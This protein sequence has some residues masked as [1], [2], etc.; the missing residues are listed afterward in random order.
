[1]S[2]YAS[3]VGSM[4]YVMVCTCSD[5]SHVVSVDSKFM[6][7]PGKIHWE[8][9][10][11]IFQYLK[12]IVDMGLV[13]GKYNTTNNIIGYVD[14]DYACD[15]DKRRSLTVYVFTLLGCAISWKATLQ[16][17]VT[18]STTETEY[19]AAVEAVKEAI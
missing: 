9:V 14:S 18:L 15:L 3:V 11:C 19:M 4:I 17:T 16:S 2:P 8:A 12:G 6:A 1:M 5:I 7:S 13:F 10:K